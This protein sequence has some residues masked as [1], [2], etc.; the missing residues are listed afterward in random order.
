MSKYRRLFAALF[1]VACLPATLLAQEPARVTGRVTGAEGNPEGA[2]L[3]RINS[4]TAGATTAPNGTY[5]LVIPAARIRAGQSVQITASRVGLAAQT[6]TITLAPGA[7]LTQNFQLGSDVLLLDELVATGQGTERQRAAVGATVNTVTA[8]EITQS[9]ESNI[10]A[11]LAGKAPNV[12]VTSSSGDPGSGAYFR[13]R[14]ANTVFGGTQ[15]LIVVD[16]IPIDNSTDRTEGTTTGT[17]ATN[18]AADINPNDVE[19]IEILKGAAATTLY[20]SRGSSGVVLITTKRGRPGQNTIS[21]TVSAQADEVNAV[22]PLQQRFARGTSG[23]ASGRYENTGATANA[24][25]GLPLACLPNCREGVDVFDHARELYHTGTLLDQNLTL[26]GGSEA[27]T[28]LLSLGSNDHQ[29]IIVN[30]SDYSRKTVRLKGSHTFSDR[31]TVGGNFNYVE[32]GGNLIQTGSNTAGIQLGALR[33]PAEFDNTRF[34]NEFGLHRSYQ[35]PNSDILEAG[36]GYDNPFWVINR[37]TNTEN[38]DRFIGNVDLNYQLVDWLTLGFLGGVDRGNNTKLNLFPKSSSGG[39]ESGRVIRGEFINTIYDGNL[40]LTASNRPLAENIFATA[41]FGYNLND[42]RFRQNLTDA[43]TLIQGQNQLD[44]TVTRTPDESFVRVRTEGLFGQ[45]AFEAWDQ[46]YVTPAVRWEGSSGFGGRTL[47][48]KIETSWVFTEAL[49]DRRPSFL[50]LGRLRF[51]YGVAGKQPPA[52][53]NVTGAVTGQIFDSY[54]NTY[55]PSV[56]FQGLEGLQPQGTLGNPDI[57]PERTAGIDLGAEFAFFRN[58]VSLGVTRYDESTTD[59][60][61]AQP[62]AP[63][64]GYTSE[65]TNIGQI[66]ND[67][68]EVT[69]GLRPIESRRFTWN[70]DAQWATNNSCVRDLGGAEFISLNGFTGAL[71]G[72]FRPDTNENGDIT[73]CY[74]FN[75]FYAGDWVRFGRGSLVTERD[76][77]G[78]LTGSNVSIDSAYA[79]QFKEGDLYVGG[80]GLPL[81]DPQSRAIGNMNPDFTGSVRNSVTLFNNLRVSALVDYAYGAMRWNGTAGALT[82]FGTHARTLKFQGVGGDTSFVGVGPGAGRPILINWQNW[83]RGQG[84]SFNGPDVQDYVEANWAKLRDISLSYSFSERQLGTVGALDRLGISGLTVSGTARNLY[85]W[86][87]YV[88]VDPESNLTGQSAGRGLDY[89]HNPQTRSYGISVTLTR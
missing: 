89:F 39:F 42:T 3:V 45:V 18:R 67:G 80:D 53:A 78:R 5:T 68:W 40:T 29:G 81:P 2:V 85:T 72:L 6:R 1:A 64:R 86:T 79:G 17:V 27:T 88:G 71:T 56:I 84:N 57:K 63:S 11:A 13:I 69:L 20:G 36:R 28:Y 60:I 8:S 22:H 26:S 62:I 48:P 65:W 24:N 41:T 44:Y 70:V 15:P 54:I 10:V 66:D 9:R 25:Y 43:S 12:Q 32:A 82:N 16:G 87:N 76:Q 83:V 14:G 19:S 59:V 31:F 61:L 34:L 51:S 30:N 4:L 49:G 77:F 47:Y 21:Y 52:Y 75:T 37:Q 7:N 74:E 33:T 50:D 46:L 38:V 23:L 73:K 58:R 35:V 55:G